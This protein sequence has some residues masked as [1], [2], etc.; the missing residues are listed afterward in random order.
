MK[1]Q[2][3]SKVPSVE[4]CSNLCLARS[5]CNAFSYKFGECVL[6]TKRTNRKKKAGAVSAVC[7]F[8]ETYNHRST[9][10]VPE[11][12]LP[13]TLPPATLPPVSPSDAPRMEVGEASHATPDSATL[14]KVAVD[15]K[16]SFPKATYSLPKNVAGK[17]EAQGAAVGGKLYVFG[18]FE[19][20]Y[21]KMGRET[22]EFNPSTRKWRKRT[23]IPSKWLG[24]THMANAADKATGSIFLV[25]GITVNGGNFPN[26]ASGSS[27]AFQYHAASDTW[28][29]LP[30]LPMA[31]GGGAAV[32]LNNKL[33][34]FN[35][36][37]FDG[38]HGGFLKDM[39][40]HWALDLGNVAAGW[41]TLAP[42]SVGRNHIGGTVWGGKIYA[43]GGQFFEEEGCTNQKI[44]EVYDPQNNKWSR[45]ANLPVGT[46]HISPA[47]L[48]TDHGIII[49]GGVTDRNNRCKPP[50]A[51]R[52]QLLFY[53]PTLNTW[54][55][56]KNPIKGASQVSGFI[57]GSIWAQHG[58]NVRQIKVGWTVKKLGQSRRSIKPD[59][60]DSHDVATKL[61]S[62]L[63]DTSTALSLKA[64]VSAF[65]NVVFLF[66]AL[67]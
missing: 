9:A 21:D 36:A 42:N 15:L 43:I 48:T 12:T 10:Q 53:N 5:G 7:E 29:T 57:D 11:A 6:K 44:A 38:K 30:S 55:D 66:Y 40:T 62:E 18:G 22:W 47:T 41:E 17:N 1:K 3:R 27:D 16:L 4:K 8:V 60:V 64:P 26:G 31:R 14:Q 37:K 2:Y 51:A 25:G 39:T 61:Q 32:V 13:A 49:V 45:I 67:Y 19:N 24:A 35:G 52:E 23:P 58:T 33:H 54:K 34:F 63:S 65:L 46:G 28:T 20:G 56:F 50:G 59:A